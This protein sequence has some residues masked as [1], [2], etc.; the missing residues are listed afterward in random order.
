[1][2]VSPPDPE[3]ITV[4]HVNEHKAGAIPVN[5]DTG[6]AAGDLMF[7][8]MLVLMVP[9]SCN[10]YNG[11]M[12]PR[13]CGNPE[14]TGQNLVVNKLTLE[15]D[16]HYSEYAKCNV[17]VNGTDQHGNACEDGQYCCYCEHQ[18]PWTPNGSYAYTYDAPYP[19]C[20][21]RVGREDLS[22]HWGGSGGHWIDRCNVS[23]YT[24]DQCFQGAAI[25]KLNE[26]GSLHAF[27]YSSLARGYCASPF[28]EECTWDA[29]AVEKIVSRDC[30]VRV[31]GDAVQQ[32]VPSSAC[33][34][35]CGGHKTNTSSWCW[36]DCF[37]RAALGAESGRPGGKVAGMSLGAMTAAWEKPFL[38]EAHGGCPA[39]EERPPWFLAS[40]R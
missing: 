22:V 34:D 29:V 38:P 21:N 26:T 12:D 16:K 9:L 1:M 30:H 33:L 25:R 7:D 32:S 3:R 27:W 36:T 17:G 13:L 10:P 39:L 6:N 14:A 35:A 5:M 23:N 24:V 19:E 11:S 15:V 28:R 2:A 8:L 4:Y 18:K 31:F 37:Y 20:S 40:V